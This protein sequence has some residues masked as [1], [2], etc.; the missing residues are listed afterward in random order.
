[1]KSVQETLRRATSCLAAARVAEARLEAEWLLSDVAHC[2]RLDLYRAPD[3]PLADECLSGYDAAVRRRADGEP[4]QYLLGRVE[5]CGLELE[6]GPNVLIP[7]PETE[8]LAEEAVS[9]LRRI[10]RRQRSVT[11]RSGVVRFADIGT[12]SGCLAVTL[13]SRVKESVGLATVC[14]SAALSVARRNAQRHGVAER[15]RFL[16]GDLCEPAIARGERAVDLIVANLPYIPTSAIAGLAPEVRDFEPRIALDGGCDGLELLR[17]LFRTAGPL[18]SM[19]GVLLIEVGMDQSRR[20][21]S[22]AEATG[23]TVQAILSD[24]AGIERFLVLTHRPATQPRFARRHLN[25][26]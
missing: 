14:S 24:F 15:L 19:R 23:W 21:A 20:A 4:L 26:Q 2:S 12:G 7:R 3:H 8:L 18:L 25:N 5:F 16:Q 17:R 10:D 9:T 1:M 22:L 13:A 11:P 6:V